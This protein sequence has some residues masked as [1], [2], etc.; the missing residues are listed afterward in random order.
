M[1]VIILP[2]AP[3]YKAGCWTFETAISNCTVPEIG[4]RLGLPQS[5]LRDGIEVYGAYRFPDFDDFDWGAMT[6]VSTD[7][8][9]SYKGGKQDYN[10][11]AFIK[12][13]GNSGGK[14]ITAKDIN[15][16]KLEWHSLMGVKKLVKV[17]AICKDTVTAYP[18]GS[19]FTPQF[20]MKKSIE[21]FKGAT[22][23]PGSTFHQ[24]TM[25]GIK[26]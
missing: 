20:I 4:R 10:L 19:I 14:P 13:F 23:M 26:V 6:D 8:F 22:I 12:L 16:L 15:Q 21:C 5:I 24:M 3:E 1:S 11:A 18:K 17:V 9:I 7:N 2:G 25:F